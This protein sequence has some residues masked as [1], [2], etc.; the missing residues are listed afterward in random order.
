MTVSALVPSRGLGAGALRAAAVVAL[1]AGLSA[2]EPGASEAGR[3]PTGVLPD[4]AAHEAVG[5]APPGSALAAVDALEVRG[6]APRTGYDRDLFGAGWV[7][8]DRNGCDTRNDVL[9]RDL[10]GETFRP[11]TRDCVVLTGTLA[12]SYSG[13]VIEFRRGEG[14][15]EAVQIDHV[16]ALS[17]AWQKGA[18]R[19]DPAQRTA[20]AN[21]PLNLLAVD[22]PLNMQKGDG[23]AATWLP[24]ATSYRCAYVARQVAV[25]AGYGLWVTEAERNAMATVLATCPD[26]PLPAAVPAAQEPGATAADQVSYPD[27]DA[28]RAAGVAPIRTGEPG[29]RP[30]FD[31]D[32]DGVGCE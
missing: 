16:V 18:Q 29:W 19:W 24:P 10:A 21:D 32:G 31:G 4:G 12:D 11:G 27:C 22:G 25:K 17:D 30:S 26:E 28:V 2:C 1:V 23:D 8:T 20:F 7:D 15:S 6:R 13:R 9:A 3:P 5:A 14:T